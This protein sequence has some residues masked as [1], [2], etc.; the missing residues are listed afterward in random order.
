MHDHQ[1]L[2]F[3]EDLWYG[4][5]MLKDKTGVKQDIVRDIIAFST[6]ISAC[7]NLNKT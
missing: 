1:P 3:F 6:Q 5:L 7:S 4:L 2:D